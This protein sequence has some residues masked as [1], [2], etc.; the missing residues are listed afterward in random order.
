[1]KKWEW[2]IFPTRGSWAGCW[3]AC[4]CEDSRENAEKTARS[5]MCED[6]SEG[7]LDCPPEDCK[8]LVQ[9]LEEGCEEEGCE[10]EGCEEEG[11]ELA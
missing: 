8:V 7:V 4:G 2:G 3:Y 9:V 10:E 1:M 11:C 5:V 6:W